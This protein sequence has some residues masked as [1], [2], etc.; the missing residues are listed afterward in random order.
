MTREIRRCCKELPCP[1]KK[2][3]CSRR[4]NS[5]LRTGFG[6][7]CSDANAL[8]EILGHKIANFPCAQGICR[9]RTGRSSAMRAIVVDKFGPPESLRVAEVPAPVPGPGEVLVETH[10]A[11]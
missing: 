2:I 11:P 3:P 6:R 1:R 10:A 9:R 8:A 4:K 7:N 5:L